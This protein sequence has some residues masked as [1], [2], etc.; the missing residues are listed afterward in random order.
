MSHDCL[1]WLKRS[2]TQP[3]GSTLNIGHW[4]FFMEGYYNQ[5]RQVWITHHILQS[6]YGCGAWSWVSMGMLFPHK[7]ASTTTGDVFVI[8]M[9]EA[10]RKKTRNKYLA[11]VF[12]ARAN[13]QKYWDCIAE[14]NNSYL[15]GNNKYPEAPSIALELLNNYMSGSNDRSTNT[16]NP[17]GKPKEDDDNNNNNSSISRVTY[18]LSIRTY[19]HLKLKSR[20]LKQ[21]CPPIQ[22]FLSLVHESVSLQKHKRFCVD[23]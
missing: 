14:L 10:E 4:A 3:K 15:S 23:M 8:T 16:T 2:Y 18:L 21:A 11:C 6:I 13:Q 5:T 9:D 1:K 22:T 20:I 12:I 17:R 7:R 19:K